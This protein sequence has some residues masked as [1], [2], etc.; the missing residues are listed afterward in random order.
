MAA[1]KYA[2]AK[3]PV[4]QW[5]AEDASRTELPF[6]AQIVE[7]VI[8]AGANVINI[9]DTVGYATP[10]EYGQIFKYLKENVP[11]I[12]KVDLS[13]HCHDDLG[14]A[15][16]NSLAAVENG[17]TQV[18]GTINGIGERAGNTALEEVAVALRYRKDYYK[19][20]TRLESYK[21]LSR[22]SS[23]VSKLTGMVVPANKAVVGTNAFAHESGIHQDGV[24]KEKTTYEIISPELVGFH[25]NSFSTW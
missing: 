15:V 8:Q 21:K 22:T 23:I 4:V 13:T 18:E 19:A 17:A 14:M 2:A 6:L 7:E 25:S 9:P 11:S 3:F 20:E 10:V 12:D 5:S 16:A 24:L 1:V